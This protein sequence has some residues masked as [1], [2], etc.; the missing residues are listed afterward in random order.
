MKFLQVL[1]LYVVVNFLQIRV[2][3]LASRLQINSIFYYLLFYRAFNGGISYLYLPNDWINIGNQN[4]RALDCW[5]HQSVNLVSIIGETSTLS[6]YISM[7][8]KIYAIISVNI[9]VSW[10]SSWVAF[11]LKTKE[12]HFLTLNI[13]C[14]QY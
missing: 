3:S 1:K 12:F 5:R 9:I 11:N 7:V 14:I 8:S 10:S 13:L 4:G 6:P 2:V